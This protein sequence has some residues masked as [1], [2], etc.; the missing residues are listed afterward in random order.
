MKPV[1]FSVPIYPGEHSGGLTKIMVA[2]REWLA[3][4]FSPE[5]D[6][7]VVIGPIQ[8]SNNQSFLELQCIPGSYAIDVKPKQAKTGNYNEITVSGSLNN[9]IANVLQTLQTLRYSELI[10]VTQDRRKR[11]RII[12]NIDA[13]MQLS[14]NEKIQ[15][16]QSGQQ[17][18]DIEL[19]MEIEQSPPF[20]ID[21]NSTPADLNAIYSN[22]KTADD[23]AP[24]IKISA[25]QLT[26]TANN[27][28]VVEKII[29]PTSI[30]FPFSVGSFDGGNDIVED[31]TISPN[32]K[33]ISHDVYLAPGDTL[34]FNGAPTDLPFF[35]ATRKLQ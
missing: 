13:A 21:D 24:T 2:P 29:F 32:N 16:K 10:V 25:G 17:V 31:T 6:S 11:K 33:I 27:L 14:F 28:M 30:A 7:G 19:T 15:N 34:Y 20:Y 9:S 5:F 1:Y 3:Q 26:Y 18:I 22:N 35:L 8:L 4:P 12:G 23:M